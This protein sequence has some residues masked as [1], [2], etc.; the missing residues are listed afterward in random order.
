MED[1]GQSKICSEV[2]QAGDP[3]VQMKSEASLLENSLLLRRVG[4]FVVCVPSPD[5][6]RPTHIVEGK[7]SLRVHPLNVNIIQKTPKL[8]HRINHHREYLIEMM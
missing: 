8:I 1:D 3:V 6:M 5:W 7:F 4:L 2:W